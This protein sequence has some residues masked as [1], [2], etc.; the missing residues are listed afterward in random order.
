MS[1]LHS[2]LWLNTIPLYGYT[3]LSLRSSIRV[4]L[5]CLY[6]LAIM[7]N[8]ALNIHELAFVWA[9][10]FNFLGYDCWVIWE[11]CLVFWR[12]TRLFS[13]VSVP[14]YISTSNVWG[15][16]ILYISANTCYYLPFDNRLPSGCEIVPY[17]GFDLHF[18]NEQ[19]CWPYFLCTSW[20]LIYLHWKNAY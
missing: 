6:I 13:Q 12:T 10:V 16:Q 17:C 14:F 1:V 20:N 8:A 7:N 18:P 9:Y 19:W 11:I 5:G 15:L 3:I 2:F 4:L